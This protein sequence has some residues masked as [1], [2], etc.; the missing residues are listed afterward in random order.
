MPTTLW[1]LT[2]EFVGRLQRVDDRLVAKMDLIRTHVLLH[3]PQRDRVGHST[4]DIDAPDQRIG[5]P[6]I[7][8]LWC[9]I[10]VI[11]GPCDSR[12]FFELGDFTIRH[13]SFNDCESLIVECCQYF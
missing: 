9:F 10:R 6:E 11:F 8:I 7:A 4:S 5:D 13:Q 2:F 12:F 1:K 3:H